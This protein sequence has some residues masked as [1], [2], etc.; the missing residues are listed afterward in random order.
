M[1]NGVGDGDEEEEE[2]VVDGAKPGCDAPST[3]GGRETEEYST[4]VG[5]G[6]SGEFETNCMAEDGE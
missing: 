2:V 4:A 1:G 5:D 3:S 6:E